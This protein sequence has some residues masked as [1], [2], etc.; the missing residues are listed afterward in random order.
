VLLPF[1]SGLYRVASK[2]PHVEL[3]PVWMENLGRVL[4]KGETIPVPLLCSINFGSPIQL[5]TSEE[6]DAFLERTRK[7]LLDLA[8]SVRP[9]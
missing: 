3:V 4:P 7:A 1:K 9:S 2:R 8:A 5:Q 6:R